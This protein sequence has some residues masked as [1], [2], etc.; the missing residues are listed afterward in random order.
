MSFVLHRINIPHM[1]KI[2]RKY[3]YPIGRSGLT[4]VTNNVNQNAPQERLRKW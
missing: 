2:H 3:D 4:C 1:Q